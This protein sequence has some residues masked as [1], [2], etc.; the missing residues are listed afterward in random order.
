MHVELVEIAGFDRVMTGIVWAR[1]ELVDDHGAV[2]LDE[3][4]DG[5]RA[6]QF[7][8]ARELERQFMRGARHLFVHVRRGKRE[9]QDVVA[10]NVAHDRKR[11]VII[12]V[13]AHQNGGLERE[14]DE[15]LEYRLRE[16]L[17]RPDLGQIVRCAQHDLPMAVITAFTG[18]EHGRVADLGER[19]VELCA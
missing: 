16:A 15:P 3:Q 11:L 1:C 17:I 7:E 2:R 19:R 14:I 12:A 9:M 18:L 13:A 8:A 10:V 4:F 6:R 5:E